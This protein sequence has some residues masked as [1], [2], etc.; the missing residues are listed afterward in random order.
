MG[1]RPIPSPKQAPRASGLALRLA[2]SLVLAPLALAALWF[3]SPW[4]PALV[5]VAAAGMGWEWAQLAGGASRSVA[6]LII[7]TL[8]AAVAAASLGLAVTGLAL[9]VLGAAAV[10]ATAL[11]AG[12]KAALWTALGT[13]WLASPCVAFLWLAADRAAVLWLL[14]LVWATDSGAYAAGRLIGGPRLAPRISPNKTWA[15]FGG[16]LLAAALVGSATAWLEDTS[17]LVLVPVSLLLA[18]AAQLGDLAE[19]LAKR[20]F[21]V[22]DTGALIPGHGGLLD[23]LDSVLTTAMAQ[24]LLTL[25]A[26]SPLVWRT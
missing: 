15:G 26:G 24:G 2:S 22:K 14:A 8:L 4:L 23:R 7:L 11:A 6:V 10:W 13:L 12:A 20:H 5:A 19:S 25:M 18:V 3:G 9:A 21:G 16:G 17:A 1:R